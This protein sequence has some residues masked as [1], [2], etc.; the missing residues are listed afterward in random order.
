MKLSKLNEIA[1]RYVEAAKAKLR[2]CVE[3]P[4]VL[5]ILNAGAPIVE[6]LSIENEADK[7]MIAKN[8]PKLLKQANAD[9][10]ILI[11]DGWRKDPTNMH[12]I[13]EAVSVTCSSPYGSFIKIVNY[14]RTYNG[15]PIFEKTVTGDME[16]RFFEHVTWGNR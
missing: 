11:S 4:P 13:G 6:I 2:E 10:A 16:S 1:E 15:K 5:I 12:R 9:A 7:E 8:M 14:R 3:L